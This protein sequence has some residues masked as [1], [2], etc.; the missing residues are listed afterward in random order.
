MEQKISHTRNI[1]HDVPMV[2]NTEV[3]GII[4]YAKYRSGSTFTSEMFRQTP[5]IYFIFEPLHLM[6]DTELRTNVSLVQ[7]TIEQSLT[8]NI[9]TFPE[10][11]WKRMMLCHEGSGCGQIENYNGTWLQ[12]A[13]RHCQ[14]AK[15]RA[16]KVRYSMIRFYPSSNVISPCTIIQMFELHE[17]DLV[18]SVYQV[19]SSE[20]FHSIPYMYFILEPLHLL[21]DTKIQKCQLDTTNHCAASEL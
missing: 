12:Q 20:M 21:N 17:D 16:I 6:N 2:A 19:S 4:V 1:L 3:K 13:I 9:E 10:T 5:Y 15:I 11:P 18:S 8:C 7:Q 14:N